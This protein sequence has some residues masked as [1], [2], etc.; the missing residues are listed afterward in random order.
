MLA[1]MLV[2]G[3]YPLG[4]VHSRKQNMMLKNTIS[5]RAMALIA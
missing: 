5:S 4:L 2:D 3:Y 1:A